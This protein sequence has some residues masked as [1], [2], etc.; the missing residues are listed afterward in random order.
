MKIVKFLS[1]LG[2]LIIPMILLIFASIEWFQRSIGVFVILVLIILIFLYF[3]L[4][5]IRDNVNNSSWEIKKDDWADFL[6]AYFA[7]IF[8]YNL[9]M[10]DHISAVFASALVGL[11]GA[12]VFKKHEKA[13]FAGSFLGMAEATVFG[14]WGFIVAG[15]VM[16]IVY[17]FSKPLFE[18]VGGKLGTVAFTGAVIAYLLQD[19]NPLIGIQFTLTEGLY[20]IIASIAGAVIT[21]LFSRIEGVSVVQAS[22][23]VGLFFV[24]LFDYELFSI[25]PYIAIAGFG[26][27][28]VGMT[29]KNHLN[30]IWMVGTGGLLFGVI[31]YLSSGVFS[32]F[33]GKLGT[34]AFLSSVITIGLFK[35]IHRFISGNIHSTDSH[36]NYE[37]EVA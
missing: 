31:Y 18:G 22:S 4:K 21:R 35:M 32:G 19:L 11:I 36:H 37:K 30:K 27:S 14:A 33:G 13:I 7:S 16:A 6:F 10:F 8:T 34:I 26:G 24:I 3:A 5:T 17:V 20:L 2:L 15:L 25:S 23:V 12:S 29:S 28:F 9:A 1:F